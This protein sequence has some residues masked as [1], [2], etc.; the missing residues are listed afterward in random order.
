[1]DDV[2]RVLGPGDIGAAAGV[3]G[4]A[5]VED[6]VWSYLVD[7]EEHRADRL[8]LFFGT[9]ARVSVGYGW[10]HATSGIESVT[11]WAPPRR[12]IVPDEHVESFLEI[13]PM[14]A[15]GGEA[16]L[17]DFFGRVEEHHPTEPHWYLS[18]IATDN[19]Y[20]GHGIGMTLL[21]RD[22]AIVDQ[23]HMPCYL[24]SSNPRNE[25]RY[26]AAGF[27]VMERFDACAGGPELTMMW[28]TAR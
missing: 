14:V 6:P 2:T 27:E 24:E 16:R 18:V 5:F 20:R 4:R 13:V 10:L 19:E 17:H 21:A 11:L 26:R 1:V 15:P 8:A 7:D 23:T 25:P 28:R 9:L 12:S 3:M 22:L